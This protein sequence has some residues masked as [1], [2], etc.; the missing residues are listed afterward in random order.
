MNAA[1]FKEWM[2]RR[3]YDPEHGKNVPVDVEEEEE[4]VS[5][6]Q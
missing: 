5:T 2:I 1:K 4:E 6:P 3:Q